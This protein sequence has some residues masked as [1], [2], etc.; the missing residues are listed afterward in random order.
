[1]YSIGYL[2]L[3][4][5]D[6]SNS[7][8]FNFLSLYQANFVMIFIGTELTVLCQLQV[9]STENLPHIHP[10]RFRLPFHTGHHR[11]P[12]RAPCAPF[13]TSKYWQLGIST[14]MTQPHHSTMKNKNQQAPPL[15]LKLPISFWFQS[16]K[17]EQITMDHSIF[18]EDL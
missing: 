10:L 5:K 7:P 17:Y 18:E 15:Y 1:M 16:L 3:K 4:Q 14:E 2:V 13:C 11:T 6:Y 12:N 8:Y 9:Y